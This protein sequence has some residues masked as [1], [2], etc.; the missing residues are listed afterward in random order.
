MGLKK[1][2][3]C[4]ILPNHWSWMM[5]G[6]QYQVKCL[7][8]ANILQKEFEISV[9]SRR[10]DVLHKPQNYRLNQ[11]VRPFTMQRYGFFFDSPFLWRKLI[12]LSPDIIYQRM[13]SSHAGIAARYAKKAGCKMV[14]HIASDRDV[15]PFDIKKQMNFLINGIE[16]KI[17]EYAIRN[18]HHLIAQTYGQKQLIKK[19][20]GRDVDAVIANFQPYPKETIEKRTLIKV[21][22]VANFKVIK[23]PEIF[24]RL[25]R[26]LY[27]QG[28]QAEFIMIGNP[29]TVDDKCW[30]PWQNSLEASIDSIPTLSYVGG[31]TTGEVEKVMAES[32]ILVN[33]SRFEGFSNTFIQA[34]M[35]RVPVVSLNSN[36]NDLLSNGKMGLISQT[37][38]QLCKDV[39]RLILDKDLRK[40]MGKTAQSYAYQNFSMKNTEKV[41]DILAK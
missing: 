31:K 8:E 15:A 36:P 11:I 9:L 30:Q 3:L 4:I 24:I 19:H 5:G 17:F 34:W 27:E 10:L 18:A 6:S 22:W 33:T 12:A 7:L 40:T 14:I 23:Q 13:A 26:D 20:Y 38:P 29:A 21:L 32:H 41:M 16:R 25:A 28:L 1:R 39:A 2:K 35:R 37:Y